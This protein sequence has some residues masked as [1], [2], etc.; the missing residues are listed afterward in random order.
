M[1]IFGHIPNTLI[2]TNIYH[3]LQTWKKPS[4]ILAKACHKSNNFL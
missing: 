2:P 3:L 1:G 4:W